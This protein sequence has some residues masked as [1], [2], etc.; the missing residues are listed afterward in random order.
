MNE[1][2]SCVY[3]IGII[4]VDCQNKAIVYLPGRFIGIETDTFIV[5]LFFLNSIIEYKFTNQIDL[6]NFELTNLNENYCYE[7]KVKKVTINLGIQTYTYQNQNG[8]IYDIFKF[9]TK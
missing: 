2:N 6:E 3:N 1:C 8:T 9:C 5:E 4:K 7:F